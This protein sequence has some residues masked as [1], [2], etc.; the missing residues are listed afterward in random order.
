V[1][2]VLQGHTLTH[3]PRCKAFEAEFAAFLGP[4]AHAVTVSSCMAALHLACLHFGFGPGDDVLVAA[5]TH[6]ATAHAVE[7]TGARPVFVDCDERTGN[8]TAD[9]VEAAV[10]PRTK[11]LLLVHFVGIPCDMPA[12]MQVAERHHL[13]VIEDCA[14]ALGA[15]RDGR[16]V[17]LFGDA[18][19]F[20]F[21]PVKHLTTAEGG[22]FVSRHR[23]V[24]DRVARL[25]AFGVDR[26]YAER[27]LPG[28]YDVPSLGLNYRMSELQAA[29]GRTQ[30]RRLPESLARRAANFDALRA[31][32]D[33]IEGLSV[34][35]VADAGACS[36]HYCLTVRTQGRWSGRRNELVRALNAAGIGTTVHYPQPVPRMTYYRQKYGYDPAAFRGAETISD[37]T[38]AL[39]VAPHVGPADVEYIGAALARVA[40]GPA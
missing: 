12:I 4:D 20:S 22:M 17:G 31:V 15:R 10:T 16:H 26:T 18:G 30:L 7:W 9:R 28:L 13:K 21:Y 23:D 39:P 37:D 27:T 2:E 24:A 34:I 25:R 5:E 3:G 35:D 33:R 40:E 14:I 19:C 32:V 36:S 11:G 29:L 8:V 6:V 38:F 1:L